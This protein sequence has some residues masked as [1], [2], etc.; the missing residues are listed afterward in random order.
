VRRAAALVLFCL[1]PVLPAAAAD[2]VFPRLTGRVV[3]AA[4]LLSPR[5]ESELMALLEEHERKTSNQVVVVT[6][7]SLQGVTIEDFGYQLGRHWDIGQ[8]GKDNGVLLIV[9][10]HERK[11]RIEVGYGLEGAL[12]DALGRTI[13]EAEIIPRFKANNYAQGI[14]AGTIAILAAI[15]GTYKPATP[16]RIDDLMNAAVPV[17]FIILL[18]TAIVVIGW[19]NRQNTGYYDPYDSRPYRSRRDRDSGGFGGSDGFGGGGGFSGGGGGFGGGG[20]SGS[21]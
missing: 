3:D 18:F 2:L 12:T 7:A 17:L 19:Y 5:L 11:V 10:P 9:A 8:K 6:V 15:D 14:R 13:I 21:W 1:L 20:S 4:S 16:S